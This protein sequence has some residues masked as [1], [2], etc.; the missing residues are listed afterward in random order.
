MRDL[1]V[2]LHM[3]LDGI[4]EGPNG[5]MDIGFVAYDLDLETFAQKNLATVDTIVWG[6]STYQMMYAYWPDMIDD[7]AATDYERKHARWINDVEKIVASKTLT[8]VDW[9]HST[10]IKENLTE[11]LTE[12]KNQD[13]QDILVLGSPR[14]AR[15][16]LKEGLVDTIKLTLSPTIVGNGLRLFDDISAELELVH[17]ESFASGALGL[18]YQVLKD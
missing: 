7:P 16:L 2:F 8:T 9:N 12:L 6:R 11:R 13:G 1:V 10:L 17:S 4:V 5:A 15:Q 18:E 14:L 3:S